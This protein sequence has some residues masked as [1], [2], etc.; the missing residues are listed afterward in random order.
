MKFLLLHRLDRSD[1]AVCD[2]DDDAL[3]RWIDELDARGA[4]LIGDRLSPPSTA[5]TVTARQGQTVV[6]DGPFAETKE[7]IVSL[8]V[9]DWPT[10]PMRSSWRPRP[11]RGTIEVRPM[12]TP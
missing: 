3:R 9:L 4:I 8:D 12:L 10:W 5:A 11:G 2:T 6:V 7:Q 1:A